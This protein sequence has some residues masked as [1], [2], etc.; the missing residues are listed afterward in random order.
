MLLTVKDRPP[1]TAVVAAVAETWVELLVA[2][3]GDQ[4]AVV[5]RSWA[6]L[7]RV[8]NR[9]FSAC[10]VLTVDCSVL[11]RDFSMVWGWA[12]TCISWLMMVAVSSPLTSPLT[13][14][15]AMSA[16]PRLWVTDRARHG[17]AVAGRVVA[18]VVLGVRP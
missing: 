17:C 14:A 11:S 12:S 5:V 13:L 4:E 6:L 7:A 18:P 1:G 16:S 8:A 15:L 2:V 10:R 3:S 9:A